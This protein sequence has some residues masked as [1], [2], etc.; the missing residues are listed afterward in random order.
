V[1]IL[2][3]VDLLILLG[4]ASLGIG[5]VL[6]AMALTTI[7]RPHILGFASLDFALISAVCFGMALVLVARTWLK[8]NEPDLLRLRSRM[9]REEAQRRAQIEQAN[10][11]ATHARDT[12]GAEPHRPQRG[13]VGPV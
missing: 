8:L 7:Y 13:G 6:K 4:T 12:L 5:F 10:H 11:G 2:P 1:P 9:H 3:I